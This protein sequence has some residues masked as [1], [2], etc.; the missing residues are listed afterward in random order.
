MNILAGAGIAC[1]DRKRRARLLPISHRCQP[2]P[3]EIAGLQALP[4]RQML[5]VLHREGTILATPT[6]C[7]M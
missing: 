7:S 1:H 6:L 2:A 5:M 4:L 3:Q